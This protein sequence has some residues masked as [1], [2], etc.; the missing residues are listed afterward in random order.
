MGGWVVGWGCQKDNIPENR[1]D[2][3]QDTLT[4]P[5]TMIEPIKQEQVGRK[6][7]GQ[8]GIRG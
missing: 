3:T 8:T 5:G 2:Y 6:L 7:V 1:W 4:E